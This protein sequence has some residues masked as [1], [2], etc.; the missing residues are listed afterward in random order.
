M[1]IVY[2]IQKQRIWS[3][4]KGDYVSKFDF[5]P[6][7]RF[8]E[9]RFLLGPTAVPFNI[10]PII[11]D[12]KNGLKDFA[13]EDYLLLVGSPIFIGLSAAIALDVTDGLARFLQWSGRDNDYV[14]I[15]VSDVFI[16]DST[17]PENGL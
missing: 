7:E 3:P 11:A 12:L 17:N 5:E 10:N 16:G 8:G 6:A 9:I 1:A 14:E 2:A 15:A 13:G 4:K